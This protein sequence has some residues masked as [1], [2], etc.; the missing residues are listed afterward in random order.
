MG[1]DDDRLFTPTEV[2]DYLQLPIQTLY[3]W[4]TTGDGP[5]AHKI[6]RHLRY[7]RDDIDAWLLSKKKE[8]RSESPV[9]SISPRSGTPRRRSRPRS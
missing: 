4:R 3:R 5:P 8:E 1:T 7:R 6:G 9:F 2:A